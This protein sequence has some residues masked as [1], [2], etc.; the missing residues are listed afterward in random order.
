MWADFN[1]L[2]LS[3]LDCLTCNRS[4]RKSRTQTIWLKMRTL[5][6][7]IYNF[8]KGFAKRIFPE[9][10]ASCYAVIGSQ[11]VFEVVSPSATVTLIKYL[12]S[13]VLT[14]VV[15]WRRHQL[16]CVLQL[17]G[18]GIVDCSNFWALSWHSWGW[19]NYQ[20]WHPWIGRNFSFHILSYNKSFEFVW[21]QHPGLSLP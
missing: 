3:Y 2:S 20:V 10:I 7:P 19:K 21:E 15:H 18:W 5:C 16:R 12:I 17:R 14:Y 9:G 6:P 1:P 4:S 8:F 11:S 13:L